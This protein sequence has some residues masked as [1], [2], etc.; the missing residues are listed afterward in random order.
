MEGAHYPVIDIPQ[1]QGSSHEEVGSREKFW[2]GRED[3][4]LWLFKK[5]RPTNPSEVWSEK[6]AAEIAHMIGV[7]HATVELAS[8][9]GELGTISRSFMP[10]QWLYFHGNSVIAS[11][12]SDYD[13]ARR[14]GQN[15]H[16]IKNI[17]LAISKLASDSQ[18]DFDAAASTLVEYVIFDGLIGNTDRHHEN[19]MILRSPDTAQFQISPSYDHASSLGRELQ[20]SRRQQILREGRI[21]S[22]VLGGRGK[23]G[24]GKVYVRGKSDLPPSPLRLAQLICRWQP[25]LARSCLERV[26]NTPNDCFRDVVERVPPHVMSVTA[27]EFAYQL[28]ITSKSVLLRSTR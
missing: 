26:S 1:P 4:A 27:K 2:I 23:R 15:D 16:N 3:G 9:T 17:L 14:F 22:Y 18:L 21:P 20:D 19:W 7:S 6:V 28:L 11:I 25:G 13:L 5:P 8:A 24:R 10:S 12:I